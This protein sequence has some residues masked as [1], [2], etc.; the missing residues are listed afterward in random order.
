M[1]IRYISLFTLLLLLSIAGCGQG[2]DGN[3][4]NN[5]EESSNQEEQSASESSDSESDSSTTTVTDATGEKE[6]EGTPENI[7]V[8]E[9]VYAED[10][11]ALG[12]E[13]VGVADIEGYESWVNIEPELPEEVTSVGTRQEPSLE[14][15]AQLEPDLIITAQSRHE[16]ISEELNEIAPTLMFEPYPEEGE[17]DQYEEMETTFQEIAKAVDKE[18]KADEVLADLDESYE[19]LE[20]K[21]TDAG[22]DGTEVLLSQAF[23]ANETASLRLFT[24]NSMVMQIMNNIG[25]NNAYDGEDFELYGYSETTVESLEPYQDATF[26]HIVQED[27]N[28]FENQLDGNPVWENLNF[29]EEERVYALPGDTWTFG[30]PLAAEVFAEETVNSLIGE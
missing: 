26:M 28:V 21:L 19:K 7:V 15:I 10:L 17:G 25:L 22:M 27:D 14:K 1:K 18:E 29:V 12:E 2:E 6:I 11:L 3:T 16:A 13:P 9:W 24:D 23:S 5:N 20:T 8:L 4:E 30:G